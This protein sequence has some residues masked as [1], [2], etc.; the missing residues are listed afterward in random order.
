MLL[1]ALIPHWTFDVLL[2][3]SNLNIGV[4]I[5]CVNVRMQLG[6]F[7]IKV[8]TKGTQ[9]ALHILLK[10]LWSSSD[11]W[12]PWMNSSRKIICRRLSI[13]IDLAMERQWVVKVWAVP[14]QG[15]GRWHWAVLCYAGIVIVECLNFDIDAISI[16]T[17][18]WEGALI[19]RNYCLM[20]ILIVWKLMTIFLWFGESIKIK[21]KV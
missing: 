16:F 18:F 10:I 5:Y 7:Q 13:L 21:V 3:L 11:I 17:I 20:K 14:M 9:C 15:G 19:A 12:S 8:H 6:P 1:S 2:T 4:G